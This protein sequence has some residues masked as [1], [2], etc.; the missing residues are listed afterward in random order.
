MQFLILA[1][2]YRKAIA[3]GLA[4]TLLILLTLRVNHWRNESHK[5]DALMQ[6][7]AAHNA[8]GE[9]SLSIG[10]D[11]NEGLNE[12]ETRTRT[13]RI[14]A[15]PAFTDEQLQRTRTRIEAGNSARERAKGMP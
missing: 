4:A 6:E 10:L 15:G 5:V 1:L 12:Y 13:I 3:I 9:R 7:I 11:L 8:A 14:P 2:K